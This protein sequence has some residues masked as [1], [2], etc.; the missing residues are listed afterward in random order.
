MKKILILK[1]VLLGTLVVMCISGCN[2]D[3]AEY[4]KAEDTVET[5]TKEISSIVEEE[6]IVQ[7]ETKVELYVY[8]CGEVKVPGVYVVPAGSR[9]CD[10]F[11][12]AGGFTENAATDYWNQARVLTDGEMIYVPT[13]EEAKERESTETNKNT[14]DNQTDKV[15]INTASKQ[16]LMTIPGVGE[17][18]AQAIIS[19]RETNGSF[20]SIDEVKKVEGIKDGVFEKMK[21]YIVIN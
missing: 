8:V 6:T 17:K 21:D 14:D 12:S 19:Y 20:T 13:I 1:S 15:N 4:I 2:K 16:Q 7:T 18:K 9:V 11:E 5:E 3:T 10:V